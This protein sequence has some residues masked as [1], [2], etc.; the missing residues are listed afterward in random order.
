MFIR[1]TAVLTFL[2]LSTQSHSASAQQDLRWKFR[3]Q[4]TIK[5]NVQQKMQTKMKIGDTDVNQSMDQIMDMSWHV[6]SSS[7]NGD[8]VMNQVVDRIFMKMEGGP[9]GVVEFDTSDNVKSENPIVNS[10]GEMF[11]QIVNQN[12]QVTMKP[13][14]AIT[15]VQVPDQLLNALRRSAAGNAGA[16]DEKT[17]QQMMKQSAVMLPPQPVSARMTWSSQQSVQLG[18]GTMTIKSEMTFMEV[19]AEGNAIIKVVPEISVVPRPEHPIR[20]TLTSS[21]GQGEVAFNIAQGRV[22][23]SELD[24]DMAMTIESNGQTFNQTIK[25]VT[26]MTLVP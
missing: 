21:S 26:T 6:Q 15:D 17:L 4:E 19:D 23:K 18:F 2:A 11:R 1:V 25:Q 12:F 7:A 5:Y 20:M 14:G 9:A 24:L 10:M 22:A 16:L 3:A 13:T 8:T